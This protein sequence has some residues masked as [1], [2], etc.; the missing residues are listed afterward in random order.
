MVIHADK[1]SCEVIAIS[2]K[3]NLGQTAYHIA[4]PYSAD[5]R[6]NSGLSESCVAKPEWHDVVATANCK[7]IGF[8][9]T[10]TFLMV[11]ASFE[12]FLEESKTLANVRSVKASK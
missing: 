2:T 10:K 7:K 11:K 3:L 5:R 8:L 12:R 4:M 6:S 1:E 9:P